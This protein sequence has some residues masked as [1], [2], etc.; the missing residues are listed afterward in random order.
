MLPSVVANEVQTA[1][2][3]YLRTTFKLRD[4]ALETALFRFLSD[5]STGIY[6]GP[7]LDVRLPFRTAP[8]NWLSR[9]PL[10]YNPPFAPYAH[11]LRAF[12]RLSSRSRAP[13][14]TLVTT[15]TGSGKT[16]CF[17]YPLLDHCQREKGRGQLGIKAI[18]LYPMNALAS[19]QAERLAKLLRERE[20]GHVSAGLYVGGKGEH[21]TPGPLNLIDDR[22]TLRRD[23]P[24][25]LLTNYRMLDFLLMRPED[26]ALWKNNDPTTLRYLILDELHTYDGA[27]GSDVACLI[28]RLKHRLA[29][30]AGHLCSVGTSAT[31]GSGGTSDPRQLLT[32]FATQIFGEP[33]SADC[34]IEEDRLSADESLTSQGKVSDSASDVARVPFPFSGGDDAK[35]QLSPERFTSERDFVRA[36]ELLW[37]NERP[38]GRTMLSEELR[39]HPFLRRLLRGISGRERRSGPR[40]WREV[41]DHIAKEE[42]EFGELPREEQW[43]ILSSFLALVSYARSGDGKAPFLQVQVQVWVRELHDLLRQVTKDGYRF[44][45]KDELQVQ[46]DEHWLPMVYCRECGFDGFAAVKHEG[47]TF[48]RDNTGEIGEA[49][50]HNGNRGRTVA[51]QLD[52][53]TPQVDTAP[54]VER[55]GQLELGRLYL[56]PRCLSLKSEAACSCRPATEASLPVRIYPETVEGKPAPLRRCPQC[57]ADDAITYVASR[58]ATLSSVAVSET[59][60]SRYNDDPKLLAFTDSVQD[61]SHRAGFFA[62]RAFRFSFRTALQTVIDQQSTSVALPALADN[63]LAHW[64]QASGEQR[65]AALLVPPDLSEDPAYVDYFGVPSRDPKVKPHNPTPAQRTALRTLLQTRLSWELTLEFG[66]A[67]GFGRSL[68]STGCASVYVSRVPLQTATRELLLHLNEHY[69][70][71]F[72]KAPDHGD[73]EHFLQGLVHRLRLRGGIHHPLLTEYARQGSAFFLTKHK[74]PL[75]S[76]F[77]RYSTYPQFWLQSDSSSNSPKDA[78]QV[79]NSA[80]NARTW[81]RVWAARALRMRKENDAGMNALLQRA[82]RA[83]GDNGLLAAIPAQSGGSVWGIRAESLLVASRVLQVRCNACGHRVAVG[84]LTKEDEQ[85]FLG[86]LCLA[87]GCAEGRYVFEEVPDA[88]ETYY[89]KLYRSGRVQRVFASE[90]TG[91][92]DRETREALERT[93]K[94]GATADAPNLL[95]CTPTLEMGIDIG[96]LSNVMLCSVP[97]LPANYVQRVGRAGRKTGNA[98]VLTIASR[99]PHDRYFF[100]QPYEMLRGEIAPPGCFLDA[101]EMLTRQLLAFAMD[102]WATSLPAGSATPIPRQMNYLRLESTDAFPNGFWVYYQANKGALTEEFIRLFAEYLSPNNVQRLQGLTAGAGLAAPMRQAFAAIKDQIKEYTAKLKVVKTRRDELTADPTKASVRVDDRG[103]TIVDVESELQEL[104]DA[105]N[106]YKRLRAQLGEKYPLGVLSDAGVLPNYA[107]P[108]PGV[109]LSAL[110]HE[111]F[112]D[113][114]PKTLTRQGQRVEYMRS[115]SQAIREFAPFNTFYAEGHKLRVSQI[116]LGTNSSAIEMWRMCARCHFMAEETGEQPK[117]ATCPRC[118]HPRWADVGQRRALVRFKRAYSVID[119]ASASTADDAEDRDRES[120]GRL[121]LIDVGPE[122]WGGARLLKRPDLIFGYEL[123]QRQLLRE[124]NTG[125]R[126]DVGKSLELAGESVAQRGFLVCK[127]CG[128]VSESEQKAQHAPIC[129]VRKRNTK[130]EFERVFLYREYRSEAIRVLLPISQMQDERLLLSMRAALLLGFRKKFLGQPSHL[131]VTTTRE[132][133]GGALRH[134]LVVYDTVPGG[135]G[136]LA[137]LWKTNGLIDV[138]ERAVAAMQACGCTQDQNKDGCYRCIYAYQQS[139]DL[140]LISRARAVGAIEEILAAA[141]ELSETA[142]LSEADVS[143]LTESE[144]ERKFLARLQEQSNAPGHSWTPTQQGGKPCYVLRT[145][146]SQ[147]LVEPQVD[148]GSESGVEFKSRPDFVLQCLDKPRERPIAVFC[149][150]LAYHVCPEQP[151]SRLGDDIQKRRALASSGNYLVWSLTWKDL[152]D[153]AVTSL[154]T[155]G[156]RELYEKFYPNDWSA[157][158]KRQLTLRASSSWALLW[159]YLCDPNPELWTKDAIAF[160]ASLLNFRTPW[161]R[162]AILQRRDSLRESLE[163]DQ[164]LLTVADVKKS[165][166]GYWA[167]MDELRNVTLFANLPSVALKPDKLG[168]AELTLRLFDDLEARQRSDFE[169]HWRAFLHAWNLLQFHPTRVEVVSTEFLREL[170]GDEILSRAPVGPEAVTE[171]SV[172]P[173]RSSAGGG[174]P[175]DEYAQFAKDYGDG[176][177]MPDLAGLLREGGHPLP[178]DA[179]LLEVDAQVPLEAQLVWPVAKLVLV[180]NLSDTDRTAWATAGYQA[181]DYDAPALE[182]LNTLVA[183]TTRFRTST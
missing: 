4:R 53:N 16:E 129:A 21:S 15:G 47:E 90:H 146:N 172:A 116:D 20:L 105:E 29:T 176:K 170:H 83:L 14:N 138:L 41:V 91:L 93:F 48:L 104:A 173:R 113:K 145:P 133:R 55:V 161:T 61:A 163:R 50:L 114:A 159:D 144:L 98:A 26:S 131:G 151:S 95:T 123:L 183:S 150:G 77:G 54:T 58:A 17:L 120:Y 154:L 177:N 71:S 106:A 149:D 31:I 143:D 7:Y 148:I 65:A 130:P 56:C 40:H 165:V 88:A 59:F 155:R 102:S 175:S 70:A 153:G 62:S 18:I 78:Y 124:L 96:D 60:T 19:D 157:L 169:D 171:T 3:D 64:K 76:R 66:L 126:Q 156:Q 42:P 32:A 128:K 33:F 27:Q 67:A 81:H 23:P 101:P 1:L 72:Y 8:D 22:D 136:Y 147:W 28:R 30:P 152:E 46:A 127:R 117:S 179:L 122:N 141:S 118:G 119:R 164:S 84:A 39:A 100:E 94:D 24:D 63:V 12:E 38:F 13:Q 75:L 158:W 79:L 51:L 44:A 180:V 5:E 92:L 73:V 36:Q 167:G 134:F 108:E 34:L 137:E 115:A 80:P 174:A 103:E 109:T 166:P 86:R 49:F 125:R 142:T 99:R 43:A 87:F 97:P 132:Y 6:Q 35:Q 57:Q 10:D 107:F 168:H 140:P 69:P 89:Q 160:A 121:E 110:L 181:L 182:I 85:P 37:F 68:E 178:E 135:T 111:P 11:Q 25:I 162:D 139:R 52:A 9:S 82:V 45:W 74:N 2:L 112:D